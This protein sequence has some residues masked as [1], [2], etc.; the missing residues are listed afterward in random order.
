M[1]QIWKSSSLL[2]AFW[3]RR[4]IISQCEMPRPAVIHCASP[5]PI[6]PRLPAES[7]CSISPARPTTRR[8]S[9]AA[10]PYRGVQSGGPGTTPKITPW[11]HRHRAISGYS[12]SSSLSRTGL[13]ILVRRVEEQQ[14]VAGRKEGWR[15]CPTLKGESH[16][17]KS[18]V[19]VLA[20]AS[21]LAC[22]AEVLGRR[23]VEHQKGRELRADEK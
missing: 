21:P 5:G 23:V 22:G 9:E 17:L 1:I 18:T 6:T 3:S 15:L 20:H 14:L 13:R 7:P 8:D 12:N 2:F 4:G 10:R 19:R 11:V 16:G